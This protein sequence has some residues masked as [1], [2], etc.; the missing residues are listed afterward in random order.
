M[1]GLGRHVAPTTTTSDFESTSILQ[2]TLTGAMVRLTCNDRPPKLDATTVRRSRGTRAKALKTKAS[3]HLHALRA[4][5][6]IYDGCQDRDQDID[7]RHEQVAPRATLRASDRRPLCV[8]TPGRHDHATPASRR[9]S[10]REPFLLIGGQGRSTSTNGSLQD[11]PHVEI[12]KPITSSLERR[13]TERVA[14]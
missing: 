3:T 9:V 14:E 8:V 10:R 5:I 4:I 7:V 13:E 12:M 2:H 1:P 11:L 6:D